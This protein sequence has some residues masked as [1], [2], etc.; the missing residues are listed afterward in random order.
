V[1][2]R[3]RIGITWG[4]RPIEKFL[5]YQLALERAG[6]QVFR[7]DA[8]APLPADP[9]ASVD[10]LLF[11]GGGDV[12]PH[13]YGDEA[14]H[15][16]VEVEDQLDELEL[17]LARRAMQE[18]VPV[19][20]IC[21]GMQMLNVAAGGSLIQDLSAAGYRAVDHRG[22]H[23]IEVEPSQLAEIVIG[24][25]VEVN[26]RH[27]QAIRRLGEGLVV[28][29]RSAD[30]IIEGVELPDQP[31]LGIQC[32]PEDLVEQEWTQRLFAQFVASTRS[33][34]WNGRSAVHDEGRR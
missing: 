32:H 31:M 2:A 10:G 4:A 20:A 23:E 11:P 34:N 29:A 16:T 9:L 3:P 28:T 21:R 33:V 6:A 24:R 5:P 13:R 17:T 19:L 1:A 22:Y 12:N 30:G 18:R 27:H 26:S 8:R 25:S 15:P 14:I 7:L